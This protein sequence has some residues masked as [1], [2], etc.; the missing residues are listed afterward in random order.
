LLFVRAA[1][2]QLMRP[3]FNGR[4]KLRIVYHPW[5]SIF[6][7]TDGEMTWLVT[8][9]VVGH[10]PNFTLNGVR[11][12]AITT[13]FSTDLT[14]PVVSGA[15]IAYAEDGTHTYHVTITPI[16]FEVDQAGMHGTL[17]SMIGNGRTVVATL[18][19]VSMLNAAVLPIKAYI[20]WLNTKIGTTFLTPFVTAL[21]LFAFERVN[22]EAFVWNANNI[23]DFSNWLANY[24]PAIVGQLQTQYA[25]F[26][27]FLVKMR[28]V[29]LNDESY[30]HVMLDN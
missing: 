18:G 5:I 24:T 20:N 22:G 3:Y 14:I 9:S 27:R 4:L 30:V 19:V 13:S 15:D 10:T 7:T 6:N 26:V 11:P 25:A 8:N 21:N 29:M 23:F 16:G 12:P 2:D 1:A 17:V 28:H